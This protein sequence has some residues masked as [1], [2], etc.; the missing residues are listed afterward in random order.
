[1][2]ALIAKRRSM[3]L[4][5]KRRSPSVDCQGALPREPHYTAFRL[6]RPLR[7]SHGIRYQHG[8]PE[9]LTLC[10]ITCPERLIP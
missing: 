7:E 1:M 9:L 4:I 5:A 3:A 6:D 2:T 8:D 10:L